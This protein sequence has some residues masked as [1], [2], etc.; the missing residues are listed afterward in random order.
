MITISHTS[1]IPQHPAYH[2][3]VP[4]VNTYLTFNYTTI[5]Y[6]G[7]ILI[8]PDTYLSF[9]EEEND[10]KDAGWKDSRELMKLKATVVIKFLNMAQ[11]CF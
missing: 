6:S 9:W 5:T 2:G 8:I 3:S 1:N 11:V 4:L 10:E 7:L